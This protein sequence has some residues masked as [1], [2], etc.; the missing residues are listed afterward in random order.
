MLLAAFFAAMLGTYVTSGRPGLYGQPKPNFLFGFFAPAITFT[1]FSG[2][3]NSTGDT[4]FYIHSYKLM[5]EEIG[6]LSY[7]DYDLLF[8]KLQVFL[9]RNG[10]DYSV[11]IMLT[12]IVTLVPIIWV[13]YKYSMNI[14]MS[15]YFFIAFG[16][17]FST[18]NGIRQYVAAGI[19]LLATKFLFSEKRIDFIPYVLIALLAAQMH[20]SALIM[21]PIYFVVRKRAWSASTFGI[22]FGSVAVL[23][24]VSQFLP[25]FLGMLEDTEFSSYTDDWFTSGNEGGTQIFRILLNCVPTILAAFSYREFRRSGPIGDILVNLSVINAGIYLISS[26][27]W[28]FARFAIYTSVYYIVLLTNIM[29]TGFTK[30]RNSYVKYLSYLLFFLYF[31]ETVNSGRIKRYS[32]EFFDSHVFWE[33]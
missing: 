23:F 18:M 17:Y 16:V 4:V 7:S 31:I 3:R 12:A 25:G 22:I 26:Y 1:V 9:I 28:I 21:I 30:S 6:E 13:L 29:M 27:N 24:L 11:F 19:M 20:S 5:Q 8:D 15:V 32:S 2:L 10:C 14:G 33:V